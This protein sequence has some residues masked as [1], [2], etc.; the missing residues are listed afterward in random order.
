LN[1]H[2]HPRFSIF[3]LALHQGDQIGQ[4]FDQWV[5]VYFLQG[6]ETFIHK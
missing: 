6:I 1:D 5:I 2:I 4:I 3:L